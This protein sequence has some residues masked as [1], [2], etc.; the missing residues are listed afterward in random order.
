MKDGPYVC[1]ICL[2]TSESGDG[3][4]KHMVNKENELHE[5]VRTDR[6]AFVIVYNRFVDQDSGPATYAFV[7][8]RGE[9]A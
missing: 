2:F 1:P 4:M 5:N 3:L 7:S 9:R 6:D 8:S